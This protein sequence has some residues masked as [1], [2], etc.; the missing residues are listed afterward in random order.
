MHGHTAIAAIMHQLLAA[1]LEARS[2]VILPWVGVPFL[3]SV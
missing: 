3:P 1:Q 2:L